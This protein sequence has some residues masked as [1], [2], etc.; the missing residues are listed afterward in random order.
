[1]VISSLLVPGP[2]LEAWFRDDTLVT[3]FESAEF[4][5]RLLSTQL[6]LGHLP[7]RV[8]SRLLAQHAPWHC[9]EGAFRWLSG[10]QGQGK[11]SAS[12][13]SG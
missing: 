3:Q 9:V 10:T 11:F 13:T 12:H 8:G 6:E 1:M 7:L 4:F 2:V 5:P